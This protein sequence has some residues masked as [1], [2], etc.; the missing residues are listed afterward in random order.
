LECKYAREIYERG[1]LMVWLRRTV[2]KEKIVKTCFA[3]FPKTIG[4][5]KVWL[6]RYYKTWDWIY[7]GV[8]SGYEPVCYLTKEEAEIHVKFKQ[9]LKVN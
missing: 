8:Y 9:E 5:Y 6:Q 7:R 4:D 1:I 2:D 3:I